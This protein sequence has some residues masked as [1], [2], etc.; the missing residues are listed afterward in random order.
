M[1]MHISGDRYNKDMSYGNPAKKYILN[2]LLMFTMYST[3]V[4]KH[5]ELHGLKKA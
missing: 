4:K 3:I 2:S 1:K 5:G